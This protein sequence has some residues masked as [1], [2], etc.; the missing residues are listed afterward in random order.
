MAFYDHFHNEAFG[1]IT[2]LGRRLVAAKNRHFLKIARSLCQGSSPTLLEI[3][4]GNGH[5][6]EDCTSSAFTY[7]AVEANRIMANSLAQ[8][9]YRVHHQVVPP[10]VLPE[11]FDVILMDQVFEH[12]NGRD[13]ATA[14]LASCKAHLKQDGLLFISSPDVF[15][16]KEDFYSDYSHNLITCMPMLHRLFAD[17]DLKPVYQGYV[18]LCLRGM[19]LTR[20]V[21]MAARFF[22][23]CGIFH[24]IFGK[25]AHLAKISLLP[26]CVVVG[27]LAG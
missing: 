6:A 12:M 22:Y 10:L 16:W 15:T 25:R 14:L 5:F 24:L 8:R 4:S 7:T 9:G 11:K 19:L 23:G 17:Y 26:S 2:A 13:Q 3:G 27:R 21:A 18:T 1:S 20:V